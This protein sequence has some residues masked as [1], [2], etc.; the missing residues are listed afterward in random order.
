MYE[1]ELQTPSLKCNCQRAQLMILELRNNHVFFAW[2][3]DLHLL[4]NE[5]QVVLSFAVS[6]RP[7]LYLCSPDGGY[8]Y[9]C[10]VI[11]R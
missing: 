4:M 5:S 11:V 6:K 9:P 1:T 8:I 2:I 3:S 7:V 10:N